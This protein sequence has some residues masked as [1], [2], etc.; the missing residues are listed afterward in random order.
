LW[1]TWKGLTAHRLRDTGPEDVAL[2]Y[3]LKVQNTGQAFFAVVV[4][5]AVVVDVVD[6]GV[7]LLQ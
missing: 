1:H 6:A 5:V 2:K 7:V 3:A 4:V